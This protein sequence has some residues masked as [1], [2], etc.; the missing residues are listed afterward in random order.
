MIEA[1]YMIVFPG[2]GF[3]L[4]YQKHTA[5]KYDKYGEILRNLNWFFIN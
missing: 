5:D 4:K 2:Q 3:S 1:T